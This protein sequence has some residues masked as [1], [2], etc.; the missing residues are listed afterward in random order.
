MPRC[1][2]RPTPRATPSA[3]A[4]SRARWPSARRRCPLFWQHRPEPAHRLGRARRRGCARPA[5]GRRARQPRRPRRRV[6]RS[7]SG[8]RPELR[9]PRAR[10]RQRRREGRVLRRYRAVRGQPRHPPAAARRAG[11]LS[12]DR[13]PAASGGFFAPDRKVNCPMDIV[14]TRNPTAAR[15]RVRPR[16]APGCRRTDDRGAAHRCRRGEVAPRPRQPRRRAPGARRR[17]ASARSQ[18]LRRRLPAPR[19]RDRAQVA[20]AARCRPMAAMPSRARSTR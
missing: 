4:P 1:S 6:L 20:S 2:A 15:R 19:P 16:R 7:A 10:L 12:P 5:R 17:A 18:R 9:L 14:S 3:R 8:H 11:A 13:P